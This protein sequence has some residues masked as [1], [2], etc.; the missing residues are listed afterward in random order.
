MYGRYTVKHGSALMCAY[1]AR[2]GYPDEYPTFHDPSGA[3]HR[4]RT[5]LDVCHPTRRHPDGLSNLLTRGNGFAAV[6]GLP[7][8]LP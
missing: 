2:F 1:A 4:R 3:G 8:N 5:T 6:F 7:L